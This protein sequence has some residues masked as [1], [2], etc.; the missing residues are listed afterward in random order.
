MFIK[1]IEL[2]NFRI[3]RGANAIRFVEDPAKNIYLVSGFNGYGK[4]TFLTSLVWCLYGKNMQE[5]DEFFKDKINDA[6]GYLKYL[7]GSMNLLA[8]V[9]QEE[10]YYVALTLTDVNIPGIT[11]NE[12]EI[13]RSFKLGAKQDAVTI[14]IDGYENELV[15]EIGNDIFINDF[16]L[17]KEIAKF[18]FFDA[19]KITSIAEIKTIEEKRQLSRAYSEVLGIKKYEDLRANLEDLR[20]RFRKDSAS[21]QERERLLALEKEIHEIQRLLDRKTQKVL[22]SEEDKLFKQERSNELQ[23]KLIR[24]GS[25]MTI[26]QLFELRKRKQQ[27]EEESQHMKARFR[28]V[29]DLAP[30]AIA[31]PLFFQVERRIEQERTDKL[32]QQLSYGYLKQAVQ[33]INEQLAPLVHANVTKADLLHEANTLMQKLILREEAVRESLSEDKMLHDFTDQAFYTFKAIA[34]NLRTSYKA[35]VKD[36]S[37]RLKRNKAE[38]F[39]VQNQLASAESKEKDLLIQSIRSDKTEVDIELENIASLLAHLHQEIGRLQHDLNIKKAKLS[40]LQKKVQVSA[41]FDDKDRLAERLIRELTEFITKIKEEKKG[42]LKQ[43]I[44]GG[45]NAI[46][47]KKTFVDRVEIALEGDIMDIELFNARGERII[48]EDLSMGEKQLYA[49]AILK[50]LVEESNIEFPVFIDSPMQKLDATHAKNIITEFYPT[51]SNQVVV[52]PLLEKE[53][54]KVE[55][56]FLEDKVKAAFVIHN[57]GEDESKLVEVRP[58]ELFEMSRTLSLREETENV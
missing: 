20:F 10:E 18:F 24:E 31:A 2:N 19:E 5:V 40:E 6:G 51:I 4:T 34:D 54:T 35:V 38:W 39:S 53:L 26:D 9:H 57:I 36:L 13:K 17:P 44:K 32:S 55:Y 21:P 27:L 3:Y 22:Q 1:N 48:K 15:L 50:A 11:S 45:L 52:L 33:Q 56:A 8:R 58:H 49:T 46:M 14:K 43:K 23:E 37:G 25:A 7:E 42:Q 29:L 12:I 16:I 41:D 28:E 30:F 47:H